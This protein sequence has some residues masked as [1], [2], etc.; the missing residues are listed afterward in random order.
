MTGFQKEQIYGKDTKEKLQ[1]ISVG[2][3]QVTS[4]V[5]QAGLT[6]PNELDAVG[7]NK[8][9]F[10]HAPVIDFDFPVH[11]VPS[12]TAGHTHV[13][14]DRTISFP[15]Y[16]ELLKALRDV[17]YVESGYVASAESRGYSALRIEPYL[18]LQDLT[19]NELQELK[20]QMD[21]TYAELDAL[22]D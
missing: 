15:K 12:R 22:L 11:A 13:Y 20:A 17:N 16:I 9:L 6:S 4:L 1:H 7:D 19:Q 10:Y 3:N 18:K 21:A 2:S 5:K 14:F 8:E